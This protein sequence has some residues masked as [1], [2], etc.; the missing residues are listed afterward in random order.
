MLDRIWPLVLA[1]LCCLAALA[2]GLWSTL[3]ARPPQGQPIP[4]EPIDENLARAYV[5]AQCWHCHSASQRHQ[6]LSRLG[7]QAAGARP[8]GPD[9]SGVGGLYPDG[10]HF[11]H[12]WQPDAVSWHSHM[13]A[14][15]HLFAL[16]GKAGSAN[17]RGEMVPVPSATTRKAVQYVQ[18]LS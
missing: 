2:A 11:A 13:P 10:W 3:P 7:V 12:L 5:D 18:T 14:Q 1:L 4:L 15:R 17:L 8:M 6:E 16:G 9:L